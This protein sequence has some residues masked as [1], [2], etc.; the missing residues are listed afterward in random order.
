M[1]LGDL[2]F[3]ESYDYYLNCLE[4]KFG[5]DLNARLYNKSKDAFKNVFHM[6]GGRMLF[7]EK[8]INQISQDKKTIGS[9]KFFTLNLVLDFGPIAQE[10][11]ILTSIARGKYLF[12]RD[13]FYS[14]LNKLI[15]SKYGYYDY[16][17]LCDEIE[18]EKVSA[19]I[20]KNVLHFRPISN[21]AR[22]LIPFPSY[23]V[24]TATGTPALRAM[25]LTVNAKNKVN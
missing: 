7:I 8:F 22:D 11:G 5:K 9:C 14:V 1:V 16:D 17:K 21:F 20:E 2:T 15:D 25:E 23:K 18:V 3:D 13:D 12:S 4:N 24:V 10:F 6:T 19:L